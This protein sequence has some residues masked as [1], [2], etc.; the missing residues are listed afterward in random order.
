MLSRLLK[1]FEIHTLVDECRYH[2]NFVVIADRIADHQLFHRVHRVVAHSHCLENADY[3]NF[4]MMDPYLRY[5][6]IHV[7][8][9]SLELKKREIQI[10]NDSAKLKNTCAAILQYY[11]NAILARNEN[12]KRNN[13]VDTPR[14]GVMG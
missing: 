8:S 11:C 9:L 4:S 10:K 3:P 5:D 14:E 6:P 13:N 1:V 12:W 2:R 7:S